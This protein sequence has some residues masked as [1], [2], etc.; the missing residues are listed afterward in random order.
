MGKRDV[1]APVGAQVTCE[2]QLEWGCQGRSRGVDGWVGPSEGQ[3]FWTRGV[4]L[5][6][7]GHAIAAITT[8]PRLGSAGWSLEGVRG[9]WQGPRREVTLYQLE[10]VRWLQEREGQVQQ[11][12][13]CGQTWCGVPHR[14]WPAG[15]AHLLSSRRLPGPGAVPPPSSL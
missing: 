5:D 13:Q 15:S 7:G 3:G 14:P 11:V 10:G 9:R 8:V 12:R 2:C 1:G 4:R 6:A